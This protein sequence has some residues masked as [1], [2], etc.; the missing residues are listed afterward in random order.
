MS[1]CRRGGWNAGIFEYRPR[2]I[3]RYYFLPVDFNSF[4][5]VLKVLLQCFGRMVTPTV[6]YLNELFDKNQIFLI[7]FLQLTES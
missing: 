4:S 7:L 1:I 6:Q 3:F 5:C 2:V